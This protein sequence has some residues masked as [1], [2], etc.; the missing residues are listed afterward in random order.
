MCRTAVSVDISSIRLCI[1]NICLGTKCI[2]YCLCKCPRTSVRCIK[3]YSHSLEGIYCKAHKIT[4]ISVTSCCMV[5]CTAYL[6]LSS[7]WNILNLAIKV[8]LYLIND[9]LSHLLALAVDE[10]DTI[11]IK[12]IVACRYHNTAV[13]VLCSCYICN[14]RCCCYMKKIYICAGSCKPCNK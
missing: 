10:L 7:V 13:K 11:I 14:T 12:R 1:D 2:K 9:I 4:H 3:T 6:F 8:L 5:Y